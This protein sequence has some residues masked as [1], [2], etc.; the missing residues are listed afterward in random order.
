MAVPGG[1]TAVA[2]ACRAHQSRHSL[3][4]HARR[5]ERL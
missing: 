4:F 5:D 3:A 1:L 2:P